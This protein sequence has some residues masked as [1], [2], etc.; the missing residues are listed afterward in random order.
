[1]PRPGKQTSHSSQ[2]V[3]GPLQFSKVRGHPHSDLAPH[4]DLMHDCLTFD[5]SCTLHF[6]RNIRTWRCLNSHFLTQF[7]ISSITKSA[8]ICLA[9][10]QTIHSS[11][12]SLKMTQ[13]LFVSLFFALLYFPFCIYFVIK[14]VIIMIMPVDI[15]IYQHP[16]CLTCLI[17]TSFTN[18]Y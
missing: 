15:N 12:S 11:F 1:M 18:K 14:F 4:V 7:F 3:L 17:S 6:H 2:W 10:C 8:E 9:D 13:A 5:L 16:T